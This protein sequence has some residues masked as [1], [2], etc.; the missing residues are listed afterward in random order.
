IERDIDKLLSRPRDLLAG[1][2]GTI[3]EAFV[4]KRAAMYLGCCLVEKRPPTGGLVRLIGQQFG[5]SRVGVKVAKQKGRALRQALELR[6]EFPGGSNNFIAKA[7][8]V[9]K[10]TISRWVRDGLLPAA[11]S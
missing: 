4:N 11:T 2:A 9:N 8:G 10:G 7:V 6:N 1:K 5:V 3:S